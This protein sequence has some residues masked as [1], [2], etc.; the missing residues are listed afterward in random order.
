MRFEQ[1]I[2]IGTGKIAYDCLSILTSYTDKITCI[3]YKGNPLSLLSS[4]CHEK[5]ISYRNTA[6][7]LELEEYFLGIDSRTLI[8][9]ANN[10]FI[11]SKSVL[12]NT[13]LEAINFH[14]ALLPKHRGRNAQTWAIFELEDITGITWHEVRPEIDTGR[15]IIQKEVTVSTSMTALQLTK[16]C[17]EEGANAFRQVISQVLRGTY[18]P[19][20]Q[21]QDSMSKIHYSNEIPNQCILDIRWKLDK[22]S[23]FLRALDYGGARIFPSPKLVILGSDYLITGYKLQK[24]SKD[25]KKVV[26]ILEDVA[27]LEGHGLSIKLDL[28]SPAITEKIEL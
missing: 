7:K 14:N 23:A 11:F 12:Q 10:N 20:N 8:V 19:I 6:S 9:S 28:R 4:L 25:A 18:V 24:L 5:K 1:I 27:V 3:E 16:R 2:L 17:M 15:I 13:A 21:E 22:I 26:T